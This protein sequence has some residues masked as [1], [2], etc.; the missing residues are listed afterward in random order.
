MNIY[1][2]IFAYIYIDTYVYLSISQLVKLEFCDQFSIGG[3]LKAEVPWCWRHPI[4]L[5]VPWQQD[6]LWAS[7]Q[8]QGQGR[9]SGAR[10]AGVKWWFSFFP[11]C[12]CRWKHTSPEKAV[13][14]LWTPPWNRWPV[15]LTPWGSSLLFSLLSHQQ[16]LLFFHAMGKFSFVPGSFCLKQEYLYVYLVCNIF[17]K[18]NSFPFNP[19]SFDSLFLPPHSPGL[20]SCAFPQ[21]CQLFWA[22]QRRMYVTVTW[23]LVIALVPAVGLQVA[24]EKWLQ[25][26]FCLLIKCVIQRTLLHQSSPSRAG[27]KIRGKGDRKEGFKKEQPESNPCWN[28]WRF[29]VLSK[30]GCIIRACRQTSRL[31]GRKD[32]FCATTTEDWEHPCQRLMLVSHTPS[33][34]SHSTSVLQC[35]PQEWQWLSGIPLLM[36]WRSHRCAKSI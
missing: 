24:W 31:E 1:I 30:S 9:S 29:P 21:T 6:V 36:R 15:A 33:C 7:Q 22:I 2:C 8:C 16:L 32:Q 13:G 23:G 4:C 28:T 35:Q 27:S 14:A 17:A 18:E 26:S 11:A 10:G 19:L 25:S 3:F 12:S 20:W 5:P 34:S